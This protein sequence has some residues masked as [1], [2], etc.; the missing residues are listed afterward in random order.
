MPSE[1]WQATY[2]K[3]DG[4]VRALRMWVPPPTIDRDPATVAFLR[5]RATRATCE[6]F[7]M[8]L[9]WL[10]ETWRPRAVL[11]Y[12]LV[13]EVGMDPMGVGQYLYQPKHAVLSAAK[14]ARVRYQDDIHSILVSLG[15]R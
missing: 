9:P 11:C 4:I 7:H 14:E 2:R 6:Y 8:K 5:K 13:R 10:R 15:W 1:D 3:W 12:I